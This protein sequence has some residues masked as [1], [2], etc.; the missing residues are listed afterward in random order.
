[1][2]DLT[3]STKGLVLLFLQQVCIK[4]LHGPVSLLETGIQGWIR[5]N[6]CAPRTHSGRQRNMNRL[7][8]KINDTRDIRCLTWEGGGRGIPLSLGHILLKRMDAATYHTVLSL[9]EFLTL[10][11]CGTNSTHISV[12]FTNSGSCQWR[13]PEPVLSRNT[14]FELVDSFHSAW[15]PSK[16]E[17]HPL[18]TRMLW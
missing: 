14:V 18:P 17:K 12:S 13:L 10:I 8:C 9:S 5:N 15:S 2:K 4:C 1:M 16:Q 7:R 11:P 3:L 6:A